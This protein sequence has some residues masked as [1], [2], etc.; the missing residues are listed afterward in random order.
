MQADDGPELSLIHCK[1]KFFEVT[2]EERKVR[3][4]HERLLQ[5]HLDEAIEKGKRE[6]FYVVPDVLIGPYPLYDVGEIT[7]WLLKK[8]RR[9]KLKIELISP[10][11]PTLHIWGWNDE[12]WINSDR[13]EEDSKHK[14][15]VIV[16][17]KPKA[18]IR[19]SL[20]A[21]KRISSEE[22]SIMGQSRTLSERLRKQVNKYSF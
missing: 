9:G 8:C 10:N 19:S 2:T 14:V 3:R 4:E 13:P 21:K 12:D 17:S 6:A 11:P 5:A 15:K 7:L 20:P 22:A 16:P 1:A 18:A